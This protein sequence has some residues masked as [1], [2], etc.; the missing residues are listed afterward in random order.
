MESREEERAREREQLEEEW[1]R[2]VQARER[3]LA[4]ERQGWRAELVELAANLGSAKQRLSQALEEA[5]QRH[6]RTEKTAEERVEHA[7]QDEEAARQQWKVALRTGEEEAQLWR[8]AAAEAA[9][10]EEALASKEVA[11]ASVE[12]A[13]AAHMSAS[14]AEREAAER[15]ATERVTALEKRE[16][17]R[18]TRVERLEEE[19][20]VRRERALEGLLAEREQLLGGGA[21]VFEEELSACEASVVA[22]GSL[23]AKQLGQCEQERAE[24]FGQFLALNER[25]SASE[26][27]RREAQSEAAERILVTEEEVERF[28]FASR[29]SLYQ[30]QQECTEAEETRAARDKALAEAAGLR[31]ERGEL[32]AALIEAAAQAA[33]GEEA[34]ER[35]RRWRS[36]ANAEAAEAK[37]RAA[38]LLQELLA[39]RSVAARAAEEIAWEQSQRA[40][41]LEAFGMEMERHRELTAEARLRIQRKEVQAFAGRRRYARPALARGMESQT[42]LPES[43]ADPSQ[44]PLAMNANGSSM[45]AESALAQDGVEERGEPAASAAG[46]GSG[47]AEGSDADQSQDNPFAAIGSAVLWDDRP[48]TAEPEPD[49]DARI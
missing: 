43:L 13:L 23:W 21:Q 37:E 14:V 3:E 45:P 24:V 12:A 48:L 39:T 31:A 33:Q 46:D 15:E 1:E 4:E 42:A 20:A 16:E 29:R 47:A 6:R 18:V 9:S 8:R 30:S 11:L 22:S 36:D 10:E 7:V 26:R 5:E 17:E 25:A 28:R 41:D 38:V 49:S 27:A 35:E 19:E 44:R 32:E 2:A 40:L 34:A